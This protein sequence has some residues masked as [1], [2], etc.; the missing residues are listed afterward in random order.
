MQADCAQRL[1]P[2]LPLVITAQEEGGPP[3]LDMHQVQIHTGVALPA[4]GYTLLNLGL[5]Q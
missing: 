5:P 3:H 1:I 4:G 2:V